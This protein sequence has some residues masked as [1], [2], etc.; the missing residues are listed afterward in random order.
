MIQMKLTAKREMAKENIATPTLT[1][2]S[3]ILKVAA[4]GI[5]GSDMHVY[6]GENPVIKPE[7]HVCGHEFG[8]TI[9]EVPAGTSHL[10][11]GDKVCVNPVVNCGVCHYCQHGMEHMCVKQNVI[12]GDIDGALKEEISVPLANIV[13]LP[14]DFD[15]TYSAM[16]EPVAVA[17][18][19]SKH[20]RQSN[21]LVVGLGTIGL[22]TVQVCKLNGNRVIATDINEENFKLARELGADAT[23][24]SKAE[25]PAGLASRFFEN[26]RLDYVIDNVNIESTVNY[27]ITA[28]RKM[29]EIVL[30]GIPHANFKVD[31]IGV[32]L[33][34]LVVSSS[35]LYSDEDFRHAASLVAT[36]KIDVKSLVSKKFKLRDAKEAFEYKLNTKSIKVLI[37]M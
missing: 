13:K 15:L 24:I 22:L 28:V 35:Y 19:S 25:D 30:V 12:G 26:G 23:F 11:V 27:A 3:A 2:G 18:H 16:I 33:N 7:N 37:E 17:I 9:K 5:C 8:G 31:I 34:E 32:L 6:V 21:V 4:V 36:G 20:V 14:A 29:G 10:R 1:A